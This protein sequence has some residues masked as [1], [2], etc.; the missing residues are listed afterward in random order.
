MLWHFVEELEHKH[1]AFGVYQHVVGSYRLR[2]KALGYTM[3]HTLRRTR[4]AYVM[5]LHGRRALG[6]AAHPV[7]A[8]EAHVPH[9]RLPHPLGAGGRHAVAPAGAVPATRRGSLDWAYLYDRGDPGLTE[10]DTDHIEALPSVMG[11]R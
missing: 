11:R 10:L 4:Q 7:G 8:E 3:F 5:L 6:R 2:V 9:L 1:A